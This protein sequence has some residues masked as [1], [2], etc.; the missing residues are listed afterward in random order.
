M[1]NVYVNIPKISMVFYLQGE[2]VTSMEKQFSNL[3]F[4]VMAFFAS[5]DKDFKFKDVGENRILIVGGS[6]DLQVFIDMPTHNG[7]FTAT[8]SPSDNTVILTIEGEFASIPVDDQ[9]TLER[10]KKITEGYFLSIRFTD[11]KGKV[12]KKPKDRYGIADPM[13]GTAS[14]EAYSGPRYRVPLTIRLEE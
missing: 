3:G 13:S 9:E 5:D 7:S 1:A 2:V 10:F 14:K 6:M 11:K 4:P 12:I 8:Y